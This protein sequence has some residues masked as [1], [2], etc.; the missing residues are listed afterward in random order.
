MHVAAQRK[1][2]PEAETPRYKA[3]GKLEWASQQ[4]MEEMISR[5]DDRSSLIHA[6][7][8]FEAMQLLRSPAQRAILN[9]LEVRT[10]EIDV[11][12]GYEWE[13]ALLEMNVDPARTAAT[14]LF[15]QRMPGLDAILAD[16]A[17]QQRSAVEWLYDQTV[18]RFAKVTPYLGFEEQELATVERKMP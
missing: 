9:A 5:C 15:L 3:V 12:F 10:P 11:D 13:D 8:R 16:P 18:G 17:I 7:L 1:Q 6:D 2:Q 14:D 4:Q